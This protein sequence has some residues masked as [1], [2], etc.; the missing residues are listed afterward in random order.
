MVRMQGPQ[1]VFILD[2]RTV[3]KEQQRTA[4][5]SPGLGSLFGRLAQRG[6]I[7]AQVMK[8][9][10]KRSG[11]TVVVVDVEEGGVAMNLSDESEAAK[12]RAIGE[13]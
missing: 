10:A 12:L 9:I 5:G 8:V 2:S 11:A 6:S 7:F 13:K 4:C 1:H 3:S